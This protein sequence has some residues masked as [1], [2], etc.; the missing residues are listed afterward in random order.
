MALIKYKKR[1]EGEA[2]RIANNKR[3]ADQHASGLCGCAFLLVVG[4]MF[5]LYFVLDDFWSLFGLG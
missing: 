1:K 3:I 2:R 4:L 5:A